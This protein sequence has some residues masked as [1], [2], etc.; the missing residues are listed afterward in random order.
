LCSAIDLTLLE[1]Q[2][3]EVGCSPKTQMQIAVATVWS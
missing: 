3:E 1:Q 2:L